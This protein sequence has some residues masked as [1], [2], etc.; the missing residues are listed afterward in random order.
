V[1]PIP[2]STWDR[3]ETMIHLQSSTKQRR[4]SLEQRGTA[5]RFAIALGVLAL[6]CTMELVVMRALE[7]TPA[8][9]LERLFPY[10]Q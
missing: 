5:W 9:L 7:V 10:A 3:D 6:F 8:A 4:G 2:A 1:A